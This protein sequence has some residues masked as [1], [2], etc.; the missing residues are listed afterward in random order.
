MRIPI[1]DEQPKVFRLSTPM[2]LLDKLR[3]EI[4]GFQRSLRSKSIYREL[5]PAY[6]AFNCAVTAW[7]MT[8][9]V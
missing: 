3:W 6:H 7:H 9:W 4:A 1:P 8:D 2:H 5:H